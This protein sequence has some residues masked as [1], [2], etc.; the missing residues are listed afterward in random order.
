MKRWSVLL[1]LLLFPAAARAH[2][3][4]RENHDRTIVVHLRWEAE[5]AHF[6]VEVRYR[7]ELDESRAFEDMVPFTDQVDLARG[8][9]RQDAFYNAFTRCYAPI[10]A[11]NLL[12]T[13]NG[14]PLE[15]NCR[16][17]TYALQDEKGQ[18]LGHLRCD[19]VF[20]AAFARRPGAAQ[21]VRFKEANYEL[22][23]GKIDLSLVGDNTVVIA[24]R[25][26]P[27]AALKQR[28][29]RKRQTGDDAK[30]RQVAAIFDR[31]DGAKSQTPPA[32]VPDGSDVPPPA[33][34][35]AAPDSLLRLFLDARSGYV[36]LLVLAAG[37]GAAHALTPGHGK[38]LVA[39]YLVGARG[40]T[41]HALVLGVVTTLTHTGAV[42]VLAVVLQFLSRDMREAVQA[43]LGLALGLLVAG[44]GVWL[45]LRRLSG[46]AD[47]F[48]FGASGHHRHHHH[49]HDHS[50]ADHTHD[51][52]GDIVP[53]T[54][55]VG[56]RGLIVLGVSGGIVP[57]WDAILMLAV[58]AGTGLLWLA[59]PLLL[60]FSAG[61][62]SV[63]VLVGLL[64]VHMRRFAESRLGEG[65]FIRAL[66]VASAVAII[67]VGFWLCY[68]NVRA[69][70]L[71]RPA[72]AGAASRSP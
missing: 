14:K 72:A 54:P 16:Q 57:C 68:H 12:A 22:Q 19:F 28:A 8:G 26:E 64:V 70:D 49:G 45:L 35:E 58:A 11:G 53:R 29:E 66:P 17:R 2:S 33:G 31:A 39:A 10:L 24:S 42:F 30:L 63:L 43:G 7:L 65:R 40:T 61:L 67:V 37:L 27:D 15:F 41:L 46:R 51:A 34:N 20:Q 56:W 32:P 52:H 1:V 21:E 9:S 23:E 18:A 44:F 59:V 38:T 36:W 62:A 4:P 55:P 60:A 13:A 50:H 3:V 5:A 47:H 69:D 71:P 25:T 48:H 6:V